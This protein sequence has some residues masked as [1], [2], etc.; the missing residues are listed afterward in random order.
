MTRTR[1]IVG[2]AVALVA[3]AGGLWLSL[4][5]DRA[6]GT[7]P[8]TDV[9]TRRD[10]STTLTALGVVRAMVGAEVRVG[11][12]VSGR[13]EKLYANVGDEV[14]KGEVIALIDD[15]DLR[16]KVDH[17][18]ADAEAAEAKWREAVAASAAQPSRTAAG[19]SESRK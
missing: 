16:A 3:V 9:V 18:R 15:R 17:A 8:A 13:V 1:L 19:I 14:E 4:R 7:G 11:S 5:R 10:L 6:V 12:R 2:I